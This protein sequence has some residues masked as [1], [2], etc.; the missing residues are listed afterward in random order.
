MK[1]VH[2]MWFEIPTK[3]LDR[4]ISFYEKVFEC[5]IEKVDMGDFKMGWF[6]T[7]GKSPGATGSLVYHSDF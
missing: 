6:P 2:A 1:V 4:A 5:E 7:D 3:D